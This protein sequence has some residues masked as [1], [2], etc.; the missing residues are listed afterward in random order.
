MAYDLKIKICGIKSQDML[1]TVIEA[2][3]DIVG[4]VH[5]PKSPRHLGIEDIGILISEARGRIETAVLTVNP[6]NSM[7][8]EIAMFD[9]DWLQLHGTE[10][11]SRVRDVRAEGGVPL[12]KA[13][14]IGAAED[15]EKVIEYESI[16]DR[17]LLDAKPPMKATRPGGNG[18]QFDWSLLKTL[19]PSLPYMLSGGL[20]PQNVGEAIGDL[21]P[22]GIDVSSGVESAPGVKDAELIK[23]FVANARAAA[24][25]V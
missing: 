19:D 9:P 18:M 16:A 13:L 21:K 11:V 23:A 5:F 17:I 8:S 3:A 25:K 4:F 1:E 14:P 20:T 12:I 22:F 15:V 24:L 6:D 2:G 10:S 7:I